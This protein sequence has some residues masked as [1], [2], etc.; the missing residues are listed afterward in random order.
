MSEP[1]RRF[2]TWLGVAVA[3][4]GLGLLGLSLSY[5]P[6]VELVAPAAAAFHTVC[7][8]AVAAASGDLLMT[9]WN[10]RRVLFGLG[11]VGASSAAYAIVDG[12]GQVVICH[13]APL[14][15]RLLDQELEFE[16]SSNG[17]AGHEAFATVDGAIYL[18][19]RHGV[20]DGLI[21][22]TVEDQ[23][24]AQSAMTRVEDRARLAESMLSRTCD[25]I[26]RTGTQNEFLRV[27][28]AVQQL[29]P[30]TE[31][32]LTGKRLI[33]IMDVRRAPVQ[34]RDFLRFVH[35]QEPFSNLVLP[36]R[37]GEAHAPRWMRLSGMPVIGVAGTFE[38][39]QGTAT[40]VTETHEHS[41]R[42]L[43]ENK[44]LRDAVES[45][46]EGLALFSPD[47]HFI[48]CNR[49]LANDFASMAHL[50]QPEASIDALFSALLLSRQLNVPES[51]VA[52]SEAAI[53]SELSRAR[54]QREFVTQDGHWFSAQISRSK[55]ESIVLVLSDITRHK[56]YQA[57][58]SGKIDQLEVAGAELLENQ[59]T[60]ERLADNLR[61]ARNQAESASRAKSEFLAAMSHELRTPLNAIIGFSEVM[62]SE[63][64][65]PLGAPRYREYTEDIRESGRHLLNIINNILDLSKAEAGS[66]DLN[67]QRVS[68]SQLVESSARIAVPQGEHATCRFN[69]DPEADDTV[70]DA[71][72]LKQILINL[73]SNAM[74]FTP[75]DGH[76]A[77]T[78]QRIQDGIRIDV[79]DTGIGM[80]AE[81]IPKALSTFRQ[82]DSSLGRKFE[83]TG[84]GLPLALRFAQ[85]HDGT[86][87]VESELGEGT[88]V[89]VEIPDRVPKAAVA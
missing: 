24:G 57:E 56:T 10:R 1:G 5:Q 28:V 12:A 43:K 50:L 7:V 70:A 14:M 26:W 71:Q 37:I 73:I 27:D 6:A 11:V 79:R 41:L 61:H 76:V 16:Q 3:L 52:G 80:K 49:R 59:Q 82:I 9:R 40:D 77:V 36:M 84:L 65:G 45:I 85:L 18:V 53:Q 33:E 54:M 47:G 46:S 48:M 2:R 8:I 66:L 21:L 58:L 42:S 86:L 69:I 63:S 38:G 39:F 15:Q 34:V 19:T 44:S 64:L 4:S 62:A 68:V 75:V 31:P 81:D 74:K 51:E 89:T 13:P 78:A 55:D 23:T 88:C 35:D 22:Y 72:K 25:W 67:L 83:G 87:T 29:D 60:Q 30:H 32:E 17:G 20:V